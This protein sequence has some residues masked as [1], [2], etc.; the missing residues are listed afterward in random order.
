[1]EQTIFHWTDFREILDGAV[2]L[3]FVEIIQVWLK[4]DKNDRHFT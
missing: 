4:T 1:M 3:K 2:L